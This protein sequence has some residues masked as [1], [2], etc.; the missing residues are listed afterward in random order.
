LEFGPAATPDVTP[1]SWFD[2]YATSF[3]DLADRLSA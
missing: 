2:V 3:I 1:E